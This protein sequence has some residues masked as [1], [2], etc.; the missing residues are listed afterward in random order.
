M[1]T[2]FI[3]CSNC[4]GDK[5]TSV[6][7]LWD[8]WAVHVTVLH[9]KHRAHP[10]L[11]ENGRTLPRFCFCFLFQAVTVLSPL[12]VMRS[13]GLVSSSIRTRRQTSCNRTAPIPATLCVSL[14]CRRCSASPRVLPP[15][16]SPA[17]VFSDST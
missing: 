2:L 10:R 14:Q 3:N 16:R 12:H 6:G 7:I 4:K 8:G 13:S 15:L 9:L 1:Q 17:R 5:S 11:H